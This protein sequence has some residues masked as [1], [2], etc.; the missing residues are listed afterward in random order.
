MPKD[1]IETGLNEDGDEDNERVGF[2]NSRSSAAH[3]GVQN[4]TKLTRREKLD[5]R[6]CPINHFRAED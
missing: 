4:V 3:S 2:S 5:P 1:G 6:W